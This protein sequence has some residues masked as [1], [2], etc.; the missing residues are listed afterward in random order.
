MGLSPDQLA[1]RLAGITA[2]DVAAI[3]GVHPKRSAIDVWR[4]KR[5]EAA[6]WIDTDR[7]RWG[8]ILEP[9]IRADYAARHGVNIEIPGTLEH[10]DTPWMMATPD[11]VAYPPGALEPRNG[12]EIKC[13]TVRL[14]HLYGA[15][16]S[17]EIPLQELCQCTWN[18]GVTGLTRWDLVAFIDGQPTDYIID[19]DDEMIGQLV[20]RAERF[21]V[22][23]V[24]GGAVPD[25]DGSESYTDWLTA[26]WKTNTEALVDIGDDLDTFAMIERGKVIREEERALGAELEKLVQALKL[27]I[28]DGAGLTWRDERGKA[29][30]ITWTRN[31]PGGRVD[32]G[33]MIND[34]RNS[35]GLTAAGYSKDIREVCASLRQMGGHI[36]RSTMSG[37]QLAAMIEA[38]QAGL[39]KVASTKEKAYT[40]EIPGNRPF[41]WPKAWAT[42]PES[43]ER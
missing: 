38:L 4:E 10:P 8:E 40:T 37:V 3:V 35:A 20:E 43:K 17:D 33:G 28:G 31:K 14:A 1:R 9:P 27:K 23:C 39:V 12:L 32:I 34:M 7:T 42:K 11:G 21:L 19:R 30:K 15:P 41:T 24:R 29:L 25:P 13:H 5:G 6:P 18:L 22:D 16:G 2:T 36:G 26:R